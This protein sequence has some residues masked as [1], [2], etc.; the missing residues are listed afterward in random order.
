MENKVRIES[1]V[2]AEVSIIVPS[3]NL[4]RTWARKGAIQQ[5]D[6]DTLEAAFYEPGVQYLFE[7]GFLFIEDRG[8]KVKLGL[9]SEE[10]DLSII[11][12]DAKMTDEA[13][14]KMGP[15]AFVEL[16]DKL[17]QTQLEDLAHEAI[18]KKISDLNKA[19]KLKQKTG[20]DVAARIL[21]AKRDEEIAK[22]EAEQK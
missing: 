2:N 1:M 10:G 22:A 14:T 18:T 11:K 9:E 3:V 7:N 4:R 6:F 20:I 16:L 13:L 5:I 21:A 8:V 12:M 19:D 15:E 17:S